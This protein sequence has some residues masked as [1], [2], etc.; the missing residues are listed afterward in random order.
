[1]KAKLIIT[2]TLFFTSVISAQNIEVP[3]EVKKTFSKKYPNISDVKWSKENSD[4][5]EAEFN[6][7]GTKT[8]VVIK[9]EGNIEETESAIN[10]KDLP[11]NVVPYIKDNYAGYT[12]TETAKI[13]DENGNVFF[14]AEISKEKTSKDLLFDTKGNP[15]KKQ[16]E[17][18]NESGDK[19]D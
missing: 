15:V 12:I 2:A 13:V 14:E 9:E 5:F 19:D 11:Q 7:N 4:A 3:K 17:S 18:E 10:I 6:L 8:S 16:R 1:M